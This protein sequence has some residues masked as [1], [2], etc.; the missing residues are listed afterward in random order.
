M[1]VGL[2]AEAIYIYSLSNFRKLNF[3][4]SYKIDLTT[5]PLVHNM[6]INQKC[7]LSEQVF[8]GRWWI[9]FLHRKPAF[10][11]S[12]LVWRAA[13]SGEL[14][15]LWSNSCLTQWWLAQKRVWMCLYDLVCLNS[16]IIDI[17]IL[18]EWLQ[19]VL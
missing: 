13:R 15:S 5:L 16:Y 18:R 4:L 10:F 19:S 8:W 7:K 3:M 9:P 11:M 14:Q 17:F 12:G 2:G 1:L 6:Q